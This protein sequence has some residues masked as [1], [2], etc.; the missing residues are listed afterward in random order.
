M[1]AEGSKLWKPV[2]TNG[3]RGFTL[4]ELLTVIVIIGI[5]AALILTALSKA[6]A[7]GQSTICKNNLSQTGRAMEMYLSDNNRY[8]SAV[9]GGGHD[10]FKTWADQ[11]APYNPVNWTN[12]SWNCPT[13]VANND[14]VKF[15]PPPKPGGQVVEWTSYS[16]NAFGIA[17]PIPGAGGWPTSQLGLGLIPPGTP[18]EQQVLAS[19][20]MY[21]VADARP[22]L[23]PAAGGSGYIGQEWMHPYGF[24][25]FLPH[26]ASKLEQA[27]P[28][29]QGYNILFSDTHVALVKRQNYLYPP[30]TARNWNRDNKPHPE[31]WASTN[32]WAI[33]N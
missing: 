20:E 25:P 3:A 9:L 12:L 23:W 21:V 4:V 22:I 10:Q 8:P 32:D 28:H 16:Y 17:G 33:Q 1:N 31:L 6:K 14:V 13:Y 11:L 18:R 2:R 5:L 26:V 27:P 29:S 7:Q 24:G 19:G 30:R 15:A